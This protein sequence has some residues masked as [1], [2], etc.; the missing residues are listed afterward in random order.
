MAEGENRLAAFFPYEHFLR[1]E[2]KFL[3]QADG[4]TAVVHEDFRFALQCAPPECENPVWHVHRHMPTFFL[5]PP[6]ARA[7]FVDSHPFAKNAKGWGTL[8]SWWFKQR[9][10][11]KRLLSES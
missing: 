8:F 2:L 9:E 4:L 7:W 6:S 11:Q 5:L 10:Q 1:A 3:R